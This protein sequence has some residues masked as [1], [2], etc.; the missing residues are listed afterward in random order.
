MKIF[1]IDGTKYFSYNG[2]E[3]YSTENGN[4]NI[5]ELVKIEALSKP[6]FRSRRAVTVVNGQTMEGLVLIHTASYCG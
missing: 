1:E 3:L 2:R 4:R 6:D 5:Y